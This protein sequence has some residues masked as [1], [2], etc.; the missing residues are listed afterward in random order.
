MEVKSK[1]S[2][3]RSK[4]GLGA[5]QLARLIGVSRQTVYA[6]EAGN[7]V[8]N[9]VVSLKL[10]QLLETTVEEIFELQPEVGPAG[11]TMEVTL[12]GDV[13]AMKPGQLLR[14]CRVEGRVIAVPPEIGGWG[15]PT[16][17]AVLVDRSRRA[18]R[19]PT[20]KVR[21]L[22]DKW[23]TESR[24][25]LAGCDPGVSILVQLLGARGCEL[26]V[27]YENS[28]RALELLR[29][30]LAHVAG[31][32]LL[33]NTTDKAGVTPLTKMFPRNAV[34]MFSYATWQEGLFTAPGNPKR[35]SGVADLARADVCFTNREQGAGCRRLLDSCLRKAGISAKRIKGYD[36][37]T[38]GHVAAA[39]LVQAGEVDCCI[40]TRVVAQAMS[41]EFI[42][43]AEKPYHLLVRRPYLKLAPVQIL[44]ET[45]GRESFRRE[46]E[47]GTG[48]DMSR[49]GERI[50]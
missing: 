1:L 48:Y 13:E 8:P 22:G 21:L 17:D 28:S 44:L 43:L 38:V 25:L 5:A 45:L 14:L 34:A 35:I 31:S 33:D 30:G 32:H 9:T 15:L 6:I 7:Y 11:Q 39:R 20:G 16:G 41:L 4:R 36:R 3:M 18:K 37:I 26:V 12:L 24:I 50:V 27:C 23:K 40:G 49:A 46:V 47:G 10:A 29:D 42:P 2:E 19:L